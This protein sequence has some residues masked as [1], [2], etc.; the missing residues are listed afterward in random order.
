[1]YFVAILLFAA[2]CIASADVNLVRGVELKLQPFY[3]P[4]KDF[5][6][7]DGSRSISFGSVNDDYCD[8]PDGSD[9]PGTSAC[10]EGRYYCYNIGFK[11]KY[12]PSSRVNDGICDC[13]DGSD[14][15][16]SNVACFNECE[17]FGFAEQEMRRE[18]MAETIEGGKLRA[19]YVQ[20]GKEKKETKLERIDAITELLETRRKELE[21]AAAAKDEAEKPEKEAKDKHR[22]EWEEE[23]ARKKSEEEETRRNNAFEELDLDKDSKINIAELV[24]SKHLDMTEDDAKN[25]VGGENV[26]DRESFVGVWNNIGSKFRKGDTTDASQIN[27]MTGSEPSDG[28][29]ESENVLPYK[30]E[31]APT[32]RTKEL[33][34]EEKENEMNKLYGEDYEDE[35]EKHDQSGESYLPEND[36]VGEKNLDGEDRDEEE[37]E[38]EDEDDEDEEHNDRK[39][40]DETINKDENMPDYDSEVQKLIASADNART[41]FDGIDKSVKELER[42]KKDLEEFVS[43]DFGQDE[44]FSALKGECYELTDR[45]YTYKLCPFEKVTQKDKNG[46]SETDLGNQM[47]WVDKETSGYTIM[48]YENGETCWNG[49]SRSTT[50][51][52]SCGKEN[53][54]TYVNEPSRCEYE[55]SFKTPSL[56]E[57]TLNHDEL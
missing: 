22:K 50:V 8:C 18:E 7:L 42:E 25:L 43:L 44:E 28:M 17:K 27:E 34:E 35:D 26:I 24:S 46:G 10:P 13:C 4:K 16:D 54:L 38:D 3:S 49:P 6:C 5:T 20:S 9:E 30:D 37:D 32:E 33:S 31:P 40:K 14:E 57:G 2:K 1:M 23:L 55:M 36:L 29:T 21:L 48:K 51:N 53:K 19:E 11:A 52:L 56:C 15:Y 47:Q 41:L 45:E 12:V 39:G